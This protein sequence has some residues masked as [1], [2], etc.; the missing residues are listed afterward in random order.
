MGKCAVLL[1]AVK[2]YM[3]LHLAGSC[4]PV[5]GPGLTSISAINFRAKRLGA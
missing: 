1:C 2:T 4:T 5:A 3:P